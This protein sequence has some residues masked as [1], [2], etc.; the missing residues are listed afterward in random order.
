[1]SSLGIGVIVFGCLLCSALLGSALRR[2]A[3]NHHLAADSRDALKVGVGLIGTMAA[4]VLGLLVASAK[5]SYD[6]QR[7]ELT[8]M[9]AKLVLLDRILAHYGPES[10]DVR[11]TLRLAVE[12]TIQQTWRSDQPRPS[13][14]ELRTGGHEGIYEQVQALSPASD[15]QR[16]LQAQAVNIVVDLSRTKWLMAA[17]GVN[18]MPTAF[19]VVVVF[20]MALMFLSFGFLSPRNA[21]VIITQVLCA[22][23]VAAAIFLILELYRPFDGLIQ[24]SSSPL[25]YALS[26]MGR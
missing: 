4:L 19:L 24:I 10:K 26:Q 8:E 9:S 14:S 5:T 11:A 6:N 13:P 18:P 15:S 25:Q 17:Q 2:V 3:P 23:S 7:S 20:W 1:M 12:Q 16:T 21:S 22:V